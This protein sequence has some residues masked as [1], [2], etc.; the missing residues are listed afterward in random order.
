MSCFCRV[1][2][3]GGRIKAKRLAPAYEHL[4]ETARAIATIEV[5][6]RIPDVDVEAYVKRF[7][8]N[9]MDITFAWAN[10]ASF[11]ELTTM[12]TALESSI[13]RM[14]R[15]LEELIRQMAAA[16]KSLDDD[17]L[18]KKFNDGIKAIKHGV[19]GTFIM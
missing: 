8:P 14:F 16:S 6:C 13:I 5:D 17:R 15:L 9:M 2:S 12:T 1:R 4:Q 10:G 19:L 18:D 7:Q 11:E 3:L